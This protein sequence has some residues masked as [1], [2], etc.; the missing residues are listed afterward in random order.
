MG[1]APPIRDLV[2]QHHGLLE[3][4]PG[5]DVLVLKER[6][7]AQ[8]TDAMGLALPIRDLV[9]QHDRLLELLPGIGI[10][11]LI[12][13]NLAQVADAMAFPIPSAASSHNTITCSKRSLACA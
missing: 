9:A 3:L 10:P 4:L 13:N 6:N 5:I 1:L 2:I 12:E 7:L 11:M 8:V